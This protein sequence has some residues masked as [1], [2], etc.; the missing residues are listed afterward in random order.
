METDQTVMWRNN[1]GTMSNF[2]DDNP[3]SDPTID[4][5]FAVSSPFEKFVF[6]VFA[7]LYIM[8]IPGSCGSASGQEYKQC[9]ESLR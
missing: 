4:N 8:H 1:P 9:N 3:F 6:L 5:P 2:D 7:A